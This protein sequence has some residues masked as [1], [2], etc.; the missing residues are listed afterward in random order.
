M[1]QNM[2]SRPGTSFILYTNDAKVL[3][4]IVLRHLMDLSPG[5]QVCKC[6]LHLF[7]MLYTDSAVDCCNE[8][9]CLLIL[10]LPSVMILMHCL[11]LN[12][13][14]K[15]WQTP[16]TILFKF[17]AIK[18]ELRLLTQN[19]A[20]SQVSLCNI[21]WNVSICFVPQLRTSH[22]KLMQ[23]YLEN[24]DYKEHRHRAE[25]L[26]TC[27]H[28]IQ[29]EEEESGDD[30]HIAKYILTQLGVFTWIVGIFIDMFIIFFLYWHSWICVLKYNSMHVDAKTMCF[31]TQKI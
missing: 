1:L 23:L 4:D 2:Y 20:I 19:N 27:L 5:D 17:P 26:Q 10:F 18:I 8:K 12:Y 7:V 28:R 3:I 15:C 30:K 31:L 22:L 13:Y 6:L 9:S 14:F 29:Q 11:F 25:E 16:N 24:A 21:L